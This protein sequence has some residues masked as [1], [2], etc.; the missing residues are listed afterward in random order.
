[1]TKPTPAA[2]APTP[3]HPRNRHRGR[4]DF[5]ELSRQIPALAA[6]VGDNGHGEDS[7]DFANPDAVRALNR[8]LLK[9]HYGIAHWDIP[10]GFLVPPIP[11]RAD[12]L[13]ALAD[14]LASSN[15]GDIPRGPG[16]RALDIGTGANLI[17]PLIGQ[18]EYGWRFTATEVDTSALAA[19]RAIVEG[20]PGLA[21]AIELRRQEQPAHIFEH[22]LRKDDRF[23]LSLCNPPFHASAKEAAA[24]NLRK[25]RNL[26]TGTSRKLPTL[27]FGGH[28]RELW[29]KG[30]EARF[31]RTMI[32][33]S[34]SYSRTVLWF[35]TLVAKSEHL[36]AVYRDLTRA[37]AFDVRTIRMA[38]GNKQSR[39]VAWTFHDDAAQR[40]W[41]A[42]RGA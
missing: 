4:Y 29:C 39:F 2:P 31:I 12:Y 10:H 23:D 33:E 8:A 24:G 15:G 32:D 35:T 41:F 30:G 34:A 27:N 6:Y 38:Q 1:M 11:G 22:L 19:A 26:G 18:R 5:A 14:L 42:Q 25:S 28:G 3:L 36:P 9:T 13:H 20:N 16:V 17:Y 21:E 37:Q 40:A 7:I